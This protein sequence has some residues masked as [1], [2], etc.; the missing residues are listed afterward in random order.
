MGELS[1]EDFTAA[2]DCLLTDLIRVQTLA[3]TRGRHGIEESAACARVQ[4]MN[5]V[6]NYN[7]AQNSED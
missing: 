2:V 5:D 6:I 7:D 3:R 4:I 1:E